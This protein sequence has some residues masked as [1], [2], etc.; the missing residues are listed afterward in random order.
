[1]FKLFVF[2]ALVAFAL[3]LPQPEAQPQVV[4]SHHPYSHVGYSGYYGHVSPYA[5]HYFY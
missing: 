2:L 3:A 1:M 5:G 4:Y